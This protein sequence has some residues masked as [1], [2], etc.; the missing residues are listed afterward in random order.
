MTNWGSMIQNENYIE[1]QVLQKGAN[2]YKVGQ[3]LQSRG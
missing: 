3:K 1:M 2:D